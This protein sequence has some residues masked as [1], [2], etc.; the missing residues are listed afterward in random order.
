MRISDRDVSLNAE[1]DWVF[2]CGKVELLGDFSLRFVFQTCRG[3]LSYR[4]WGIPKHPR[5]L[6][7]ARKPAATP[8]TPPSRLSQP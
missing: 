5:L 8:S 4:I 1:C 2:M 7:V 6:L 3:M